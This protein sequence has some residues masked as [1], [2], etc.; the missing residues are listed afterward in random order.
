LFFIC[1]IGSRESAA[2]PDND[3]RAVQLIVAASKSRLSRRDI[4]K[5]GLA[6][7]LS[8][9]AI[10]WVLEACG[11]GSSSS[12][13]TTASGAQS[14]TA[15]AATTGS[16]TQSTAAA[17]TTGSTATAASASGTPDA[18]SGA[19]SNAPTGGTPTD[20][21]TFTIIFPG[22]TADLDPQSA[23]DNQASCVF[24]GAYEML[25]RLKGNSTF[26]YEPMLAK[27]WAP[28][29]DGLTWTFN[30]YPNVKFHDGTAC[31]AAAV[32]KSF[33]R[34]L[35]AKLG[36]WN[37]MGRFIANPDTDITAP[38]ATTVV[39]KL[40]TANPIFEAAIASEYGPFV[41]SPAAMDKHKTAADPYAHQWFL[42]NLVGTGPYMATQVDPQQQIVLKR[43]PDYYRGW[44]GNHFDEIVF[45]VVEDTATRQQLLTGGSADAVTNALTPQAVQDL[46]AN[47]AL[48]VQTYPSTNVNWTWMN[49]GD[50]LKDPSVRQGLCYAF[51]Y[52][53][54]QQGVYKGL[55]AS[56]NGPLTPTT[57]GY[58]PNV[59][60]YKTDL[61]KAKQLIGAQ[62]KPGEKFTWMISSGVDQTKSVAVL[63]QA[64]L[65]QIGY[66]LEINEV[67]RSAETNLAYGDAPPAQ[68]PDFF[69]DWGWWPDYNDGYNEIYPNF[70]SKSAGSAGSN[71]G[72][73][74]NPRLDQILETLAPGVSDADYKSL[75]AEA[76]NI[77]TEKDPPAMFWGTVLWYTIMNA[78]VRGF[79]WNPIYLNS[80]YFYDMYFVK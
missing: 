26:D 33:Q 46:K 60:V 72:F 13:A 65:Q 2:V 62:F 80:Y 57:A 17:A 20:G 54:V 41:V 69:G 39:F 47:T 23:Y 22:S 34:L 40:Q 3:M 18:S 8:L 37:V 56:T 32:V 75:L 51:P 1:R 31:D 77:M 24:F 50:R 15:A 29:A 11:K 25:I 28:S 4:I 64:N 36:P 16:G 67:E 9:S 45:R 35:G 10:G 43:F 49:C 48:Q 6:M 19:T 14:T 78:K 53:D 58:D 74:N 12:T 70:Y 27:T 30:L 63:M 73:Y 55:I 38:D 42:Q 71:V 5:R 59:F 76:Q 66:Q 79:T 61:D 44:D 68:R 7:G 52:N 21:G